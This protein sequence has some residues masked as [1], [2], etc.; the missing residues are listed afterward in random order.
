MRHVGTVTLGA[1]LLLVPAMLAGQTIPSP[2]TFIETR[3]AP[4]LIV[5]KLITDPGSLDLGPQS[6]LKIGGRYN[7][8]FTGPLSGEVGLSF[9]PTRRNIYLRPSPEPE[10][11][12]VALGE[13]DM[14]LTIAEAG[15]RFDLPGARVWRGFMPYAVLT[16]GAA[17]NL[18]GSDPVEEAIPAEQRFA[19]GP[20]F[21]LGGAL[22]TD[23]FLTERFSLRGEVRDHVWRITHPVGITGTGVRENEWLQNF[24]LTLGGAFHF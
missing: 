11:E 13:T 10:V 12:L 2:Y 8:R 23:F 3:H 19:F 7:Y 15:L 21:A 16:G 1:V 4:G 17:I 14:L 22:G 20:S 24:A 6:A 9:V 18:S 5:A